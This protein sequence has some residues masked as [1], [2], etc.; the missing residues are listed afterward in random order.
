[1]VNIDY[2]RP[3]PE[4]STALP[5]PG[6]LR[7]TPA[8][9]FVG[10][11]AELEAVLRM[12]GDARTEGRRVA[13]VGGEPGCG[14]TRLAWELA[15]RA[16]D[17]GAS[18]LY[19]ACDASLTSPYQPFVEALR[20]LV[21]HIEPATLRDAAGARAGELAR[22]LPDLRSH[23]Q[24]LPDPVEGDPAS[25]RHRL[26]S[27]VLDLLTAVGQRRPVLLV[28]DDLHW[29]DRPS[30]L[31]LE[32]LAR[33]AGD[34]PLLVVATYREGELDAGPGLT[35]T[36]AELH[37]RPG[38]ERIALGGLEVA[39]IEQLVVGLGGGPDSGPLAG[40]LCDLTAGNAFLVG[41]LW[42]HLAET[43]ALAEGEAGWALVGDPEQVATPESVRQVVGQRLE[44]LA[45]PTGEVLELA[46]IVGRPAS[47]ALLRRA[48]GRP[49][50]ELIDALDEAT[51]A[52]VLEVLPGPPV[53]HRFR[54]ELLRRAVADRV[55]PLRRAALHQR[56]AEAMEAQ[57][58][59]LGVRAAADLAYHWT[60][61]TPV[62]GPERAVAA[63]LRA[64]DLE[65]EALAFDGAVRLLRSALALGV[66]D[67]AQRAAVEYEL[68]VALHRAGDT[69]AAIESFAA[70]ADHARDRGDD[71]AFARA[72][73]AFEE[74][75]WRPGII[76]R[77][78]L[79][80]LTEA[81]HRLDPADSALRVGVLACLGSA[82]AVD[83]RHD[84]G[85]EHWE[86]AVAMARRVDDR[87]ALAAA[88]LRGMWA[89]GTRSS[90]EVL[91]A[92]T[93]ACALAEEVGDFDLRS[94]IGAFCMR[95]LIELYDLGGARRELAHLRA[96]ASRVGQAFYRHVDDLYGACLAICDGRFEEAEACAERAV[97]LSRQIGSR[98]DTTAVY[99]IQMFTI[100]REQGRLRQVAPLVRLAASQRDEVWGPALAALLAAVGL[101]DAARIELERLSADGFAAVP[102][103]PLRLV[104]L[105]FLAD[106]C[107]V[108]NDPR[109]AALVY[110]EL[111]PFEGRNVIAGEAVVC[112]GPAD[113]FLGVLACQT[114]DGDAALRHLETA[115]ALNERLG[116]ATWLAHTRFEL[117]RLLLSRGDDLRARALLDAAEAAAQRLGMV[118]LGH[119]ILGLTEPRP[120]PSLPDGLS[121]REV[122]VLRLVAAGRSNREIGLLLSISQHTAANHVRSILFKTGCANRTE[123][124]AYAHRHALVD[125]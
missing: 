61:A 55:A 80:L 90:Q 3:V 31:L 8:L 32:H 36:M 125:R 77:R 48:S 37:R 1:M 54:H 62:A 17:D 52:G 15:G 22:L 74:A 116:A 114:G 106:T 51:S 87:R 107:D 84:E 94:E 82:L 23:L 100:R 78:A 49:D 113:R 57:P 47:L 9:P 53:T 41:E 27:A 115:L 66:E 108:V 19:G 95:L 112:Y 14:K 59:E 88:L 20:H 123:A 21:D 26:H 35:A 109:L 24:D 45:P 50:A 117:A 56:V 43:G 6:P 119:R 97:E 102:P 110:E 121:P 81:E 98:H 124:A 60:E 67:R 33:A 83:G 11:D 2:R 72:A 68:G 4:S 25:Q 89:R 91:D 105:G 71:E 28:L 120:A 5:L 46:A 103:G 40:V 38:V 76:D 12:W 7:L 86:E 10:R 73:V 122:D 70:A 29:A 85:G 65:L 92:L 111:L 75:C 69:E 13:L 42:R 30:L 63:S 79:E 16:R 93:E 104:A 39:A 18:V 44:R 96:G 64:A 58:T 101:T 99:G 118:A 34:A